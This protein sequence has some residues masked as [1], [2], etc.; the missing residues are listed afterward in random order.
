MDG[1][2]DETILGGLFALWYAALDLS[3]ILNVVYSV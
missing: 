2:E 3:G 1:L